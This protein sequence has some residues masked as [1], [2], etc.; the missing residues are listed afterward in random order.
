[1]RAGR[2]RG[3]AWREVDIEALRPALLEWFRHNRRDLPWRRTRDPYHIWLSEIMLQQT[4]VAT[5]TPY[6]ER[7]LQRFP[8]LAALAAASV[9]DVL[10]EWAGLGYY[11]RA[12]YLHAGAQ[13]MVR[14]HGGEIPSDPDVFGALPGVGR[15]TVGAVLSIGFG[16]VLPVLDGNV[17]RVLSRW[18]AAPLAVKRAEDAK[19]L[20]VMAEALVPGVEYEDKTHKDA[21]A[22]NEALMELGATLCT[23]RS[24]ACDKCP[25]SAWCRAYAMGR[26]AEFPP[27]PEA[28]AT[29]SL[30]RAVALLEADGRVL[31]TRREGTLLTGLWEMP[32]VDLEP[33]EGAGPPLRRALGALG[34]QGVTLTDTGE[35]VQHSITHHR[36][37]VEVWRGTWTGKRPAANTKLVWADA[38]AREHALTALAR[39][40]VE[41]ASGG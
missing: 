33:D 9:D 25:V 27:V 12:R 37:E 23:P 8:T 24:P 13:A 5:A 36:I 30:R 15:Y 40:V 18:A 3:D 29:E 22:W 11:R 17:A 41:G 10:A 35:R 28:R 1:M 6:Y 20:W 2:S 31:V 19:R 34:V 21:G 4:Q 16:A 26:V 39:K 7:F 14:E 38:S 32:G